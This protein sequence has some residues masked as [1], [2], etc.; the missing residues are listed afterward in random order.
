MSILDYIEKAR[1][2]PPAKRHQIAFGISISI[3]LI[4]FVIWVSTLHLRISDITASSTGDVKSIATPFEAIGDTISQ[5]Y[6][7]VKQG[8]DTFLSQEATS[9]LTH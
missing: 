1:A 9:G 5:T 7:D 6:G 2:L 4:I 8:F 3:T